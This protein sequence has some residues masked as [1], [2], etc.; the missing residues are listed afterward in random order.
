MVE[1][2]SWA[3]AN[4]LILPIEVKITAILIKKIEINFI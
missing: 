1:L 3:M 4:R 2:S